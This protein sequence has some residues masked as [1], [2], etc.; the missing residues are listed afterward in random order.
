MSTTETLRPKW[1]TDTKLAR[2]AWLSAKD[3]HMEC[4][5]LMHFYNEESLLKC[6]HKLDGKK[7]VGVD[8]MTKEQY[9]ENL[10]GNIGNLLDRMKK[11]A[12]RPG[13]IREVM[14]EKEDKP[15]AFRPLGISNFEDKMIQKQT[16]KILD[17]IYDPIFRD[18]SFGFRPGKSCHDAIKALHKF[19]FRNEIETVIDIDMANFFGTIDHKILEDFMRMKIKD[20]KFMRYII[21]MFKAG[22]LSDGDLRMTEEG[23]PQGSVCSPVM[24]N[25]Y[26]HYVLDTW[27]ED[28]VQPKCRGIVKLF[29]Y[30]D[31][32]IICCEREIDAKRILEVLEKRLAKF[33]LK[34]NKDKTKVVPFAVAKARQGIS[35]GSFD[36][37]GFTFY[38]GKSR[39]GKWIP[40]LKTAK[41]RFVTKMKRVAKWIKEKRNTAKL[42][43]LWK[44]FCSK[45]RGHIQYYGVSFNFEKIK[46]FKE[47]AE[48]IFFKWINRRSQRPSMTWGKFSR[49]RNKYPPPALEIKHKLF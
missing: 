6:F 47:E 49:F 41:K 13:N 30:A 19:L 2:V 25:I 32:A 31:D 45:L 14:I 10:I 35:Q 29:R 4:T 40:K 43:P 8:K 16:A 21:R 17:S 11:M 20:P 44:T 33:K 42:V 38:F 36:F 34:L 18:C 27:I 9:G 37:L 24:S 48:R 26:A 1:D 39:Q 12:Y 46:A 3:P 28:I 15:G 7:A 23:V 22:V 5:T